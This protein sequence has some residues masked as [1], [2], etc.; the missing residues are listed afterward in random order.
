[1]F[2]DVLNLPELKN[3][4]LT[5]L[6]TG[7]MAGAPCP[8]SLVKAVVNELH[9]KDFVV[10]TDAVVYQFHKLVVNGPSRRS[11]MEWRRLAPSL[12]QDILMIRSTYVIQLLD[13]RR[14]TLKYSY[15]FVFTVL[16]YFMCLAFIQVKIVNENNEIV[17]VNTPGELCTR[18]YSTM[19]M[20]WNDEAKTKETISVDRWLRTGQVK[21]LV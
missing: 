8:Q 15:L 20:Y 1:M 19:L 5:S 14:T 21:F 2:V 13:T 7:Y 9:M 18:G 16:K 11:L 17:P 4:S 6:S 10:C 3:Y 12:F